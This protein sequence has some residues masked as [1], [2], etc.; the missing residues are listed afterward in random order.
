[1]SDASI[2][3]VSIDAS[4]TTTVFAASTLFSP[5]TRYE[6]VCGRTV[7][8]GG[9]T[10][11]ASRPSPSRRLHTHS[12]LAGRRQQEHTTGNHGGMVDEHLQQRRLAGASWPDEDANRDAASSASMAAFS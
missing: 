6:P 5:S 4:S 3:S 10:G 12:R 9:G 8:T 2:S 7:L 1:M 11:Q